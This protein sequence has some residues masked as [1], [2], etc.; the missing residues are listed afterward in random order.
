MRGIIYSVIKIDYEFADFE[1]KSYENYWDA[2]MAFRAMVGQE[3]CGNILYLCNEGKESI[4]ASRDITT[5]PKK[6][7][8]ISLTDGTN[9]AVD[10]IEDETLAFENFEKG[11]KEFN[12]WVGE[13]TLISI[14]ETAL[15]S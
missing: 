5:I 3:L 7:A 14:R 11:G 2:I 13:T 1:F 12:F 10:D 8:D 4:N 15:H 6:Y 9:N